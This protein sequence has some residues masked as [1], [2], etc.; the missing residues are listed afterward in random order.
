MKEPIKKDA[1]V[2]IIIQNPDADE[3]ILGLQEKENDTLFI[4][5]FLKKEDAEDCFLNIP[6]PP[7]I[8]HQIQAIIFEELTDHAVKN[9][10]EIFFL[11]NAGKLLE[12][13]KP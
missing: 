7:G 10:Y 5:A 3:H 9:N 11:D 8:K 1:W 12:K 2:Y 13:I 6:R 4:P